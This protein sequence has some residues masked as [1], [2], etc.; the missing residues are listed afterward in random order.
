MQLT[1]LLEMYEQVNSKLEGDAL[2]LQHWFLSL[3][4]MPTV[5]VA[6]LRDAVAG[7]LS[8]ERRT[9]PLQQLHLQK[10]HLTGIHMA[11]RRRQGGIAPG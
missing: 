5:P 8:A 2:I 7:Q 11:K 9:P 1:L 3:Q 10:G 6:G 4:S